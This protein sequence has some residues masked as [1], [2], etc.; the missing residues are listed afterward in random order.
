MNITET[1][2]FEVGRQTTV[3][4]SS[5]IISLTIRTSTVNNHSSTCYR[6]KKLTEDK[7]TECNPNT[8]DL[9]NDYTPTNIA[10]MYNQLY[11]AEWTDA[12]YLLI[13][14]QKTQRQAIDILRTQLRV[15]TY[16][17]YIRV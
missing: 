8:T 9:N 11:D 1:H 15:N 7:L 3:L 10:K 6:I 5:R 12:Y 14:T 4:Y 13:D 16:I 17:V 2:N